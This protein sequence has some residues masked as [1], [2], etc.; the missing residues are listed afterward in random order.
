[1]KIKHLLISLYISL[2]FFSCTE[3]KTNPQTQF[4]FGT[5]CTIN[6]YK[7]G[8]NN[9][10]NQIFS[11]L[12]EI[13][14]TFSA[15][16]DDSVINQINMKAG[17]AP[18]HVTDEVIAVLSYAEK[19]AEKS[20]GAF[21]P[22][23]GPL[24]SLWKIGFGASS[25]PSAEDIEKAL[26]LVDYRKLNINEAEKTVFLPEKGM[27]LDL[28]GIIKGYAADQIVSILKSSRIKKAIID[29]GGNIYVYGMKE[30]KSDWLVGIKAPEDKS[31]KI[32]GT[33]SIES[34]SVVTSG[35]Y[36]RFFISDSKRYHHI[37][38]SNTGYPVDKGLLSCTIISES[39]MLA[40]ALST[41]V[42][43]LGK[44]DGFEF[45]EK[46]PETKAIFVDEA[47]NVSAS[48]NIDF[49]LKDTDYS[50]K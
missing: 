24:S 28:G 38:D 11:R 47:L 27:R 49:K 40:D 35:V 5:V 25:P 26:S 19:I 18:V 33:V 41:A 23:I 39:S 22:T 48:E 10:Y 46:F 31:N 36:E 12:N 7:D 8:K 16:L 34:G 13:E 6:L 50:F 30:D 21:D 3:N 1:M 44:D 29:L 17:I 15:N 43:I 9:L 20:N 37:L 32:L 2:L 14:K 4:I 45:V 42:F